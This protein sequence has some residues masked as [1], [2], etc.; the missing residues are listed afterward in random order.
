MSR[1]TGACTVSTRLDDKGAKIL[2]DFARA[3]GRRNPDVAMTLSVPLRYLVLNS[4]KT[5]A[6][7]PPVAR[8]APIRRPDKAA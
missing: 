4:A 5:L 3:L 1:S 7:Q 2:D 6:D 8:P